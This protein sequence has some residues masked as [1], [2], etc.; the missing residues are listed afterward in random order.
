MILIYSAVDKP[1]RELI[2]ILTEVEKSYN[3]KVK[4][5]CID[6]YKGRTLC[7]RL[8]CTCGTMTIFITKDGEVVDRCN[9]FSEA[10]LRKKLDKLV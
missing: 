7:D 1:S 8:D 3:D 2:P 6:I 9:D 5:N 10:A 4:L